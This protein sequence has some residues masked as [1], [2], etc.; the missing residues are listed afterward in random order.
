MVVST[1]IAI[2]ALVIILIVII[3]TVI[4]G[5]VLK[6]WQCDNGVCKMVLAGSY[7]NKKDCEHKCKKKDKSANIAAKESEL[8]PKPE[9]E[10]SPKT[11]NTYSCL[12]DPSADVARCLPSWRKGDYETSCG[13]KTWKTQEECENS[14]DCV[15]M[16]YDE[17]QGCVV[18]KID[19]QYACR[20]QCESEG[21][22]LIY[23]PS[24]EGTYYYGYPFWPWRRHHRRRRRPWR[25]IRPA[26]RL[27]LTPIR[28]ARRLPL[29]P[30][31]PAMA[32][33]QPAMAPIQPTMAPIQ[34]AMAG[35]MAPIGGGGMGGGMAPIGGGMGG[36]MAG[37]GGGGMASI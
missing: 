3:V 36:G 33:I 16:D 4:L 26:R 34:P 25:R 1:T 15:R 32:P 7:R 9:P 23:G 27:P 21:S 18:D 19:G 6:H 31:R 37:I 30:I 35:G 20:A 29:T 13:D 14:G 10:P 17:T 5:F 11:N 28:P 2:V 22:E 24:Y 8:G 12:Y